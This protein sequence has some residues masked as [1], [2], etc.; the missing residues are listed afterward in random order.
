MYK[1]IFKKINIGFFLLF[2][3]AHAAEAFTFYWFLQI[4]FYSSFV[5]FRKIERTAQGTVLVS[6]FMRNLPLVLQ[7]GLRITVFT[8]LPVPYRL[9]R[10][11]SAM[12][13]NTSQGDNQ[14]ILRS[15]S[16]LF[17]KVAE[18]RLRRD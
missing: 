1:Y 18:I 4:V 5:S 9:F 16:Y 2:H 13:G 8:T 12:T 3:S 6:S 11:V 10:Q 7:R 15:A 14:G 17:K